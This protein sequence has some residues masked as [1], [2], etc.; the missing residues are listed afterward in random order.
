MANATFASN[1]VSNAPVRAVGAASGQR[2]GLARAPGFW[3]ALPGK[4]M[5]SQVDRAGL[6]RLA[7][8][9]PG[10]CPEET[11]VAFIEAMRHAPAGDIVECGSGLGQT[12]ALLVCLARRYRIGAA[13]CFDA[14]GAEALADFEID[15]APLSEGR[16]NYL[17]SD[18][19]PSY[20]PGL[21]VAT[22]TFGETRYE[23][24]IALLHLAGETPHRAF[25]SSKVV[26]GGWLVFGD[27]ADEAESFVD[28]NRPCVSASFSAGG[29]VFV[30]LKR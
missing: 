17:H 27:L 2:I 23:G 19:A 14:W 30:Q 11:M 3:P 12:A 25:L 13:L 5:L 26:P 10:D 22:P 20:G 7:A 1:K 24:S 16:L 6:V 21:V 4:Q 28:A 9:I 8:S 15:L 29:S 18:A